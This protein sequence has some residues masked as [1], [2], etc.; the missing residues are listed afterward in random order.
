M[1]DKEKILCQACGRD[2]KVWYEKTNKW[3]CFYCAKEWHRW[4]MENKLNARYS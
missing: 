4:L 2:L 3:R 1:P